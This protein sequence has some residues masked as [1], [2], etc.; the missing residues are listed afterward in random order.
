MSPARAAVADYHE[1]VPSRR[2]VADVEPGYL[3]PLLPPSAP[4]DPEPW[5]AVAADVR[6]KI[7]PGITH[8]SSPGFMAFFPCSGS[9]PAAI[10]EMWSS[11]FNGTHFNWVCSPAVTE[12]ETVVM[13]W[14]ARLPALPPCFLASSSRGG[15]GVI[16]GS[17]S[18]AILTVMVAARDCFLAART[19]RR[20]SLD[21]DADPYTDSLADDDDEMCRLR[22]RLVALGSAAAYSSTR[23]AAQ[24]LGVR[25]VAVPV[26][27]RHGFAVQ[28][29]VLERTLD[30]L[31]ARGL[32]P[33]YLTATL[34]TTDLYAVDDFAAIADVLAPRP[35]IWV[36]VDAAYAGS[37]LVLEE[38][39][40][41]TA[42]LAHFNSFNVNPHKWLLNTF[43]C[44]AL[45]VRD[46]VDLVFALSI[47][48]PYLRNPMSDDGLVVDYRD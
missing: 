11:A 28:G 27:E 32:E 12:L 23:K 4:L 37:A 34:G 18:E 41:L 39:K 7:L 29:P 44:S 3:R 5:E 10:A 46:S 38:N 8:W 17:A 14:L 1:S 22:G 48:P 6:A 36:H 13:D 21:A 2:V 16:H 9:F 35:D 47:K 20:P 45:W 40:H 25:F 30:R 42:P 24:V 33:F 15:G 31:A 26:D 19:G 43:D